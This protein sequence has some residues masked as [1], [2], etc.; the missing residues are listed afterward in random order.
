MAKPISREAIIAVFKPVVPL[1]D[2]VIAD[3]QSKSTPE[4]MRTALP[5]VRR[6]SHVRRLVGTVRWMIMA[7]GL[8]ACAERMPPGFG[9][10]STEAQHNGG[11]YVFLCPGG[12]FTVKKQPHDGNEGVYLQEQLN[13]VLEQAPLA[14]G[15]NASAGIKVF[16]SAAWK[17]KPRLI[18]EH[19]TL[20]ESMV[21]LLDEVRSFV[22]ARVAPAQPRTRTIVRSARRSKA[23]SPP[24]IAEQ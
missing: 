11:Q 10:L 5:T 18:V 21:I 20:T 9:V 23:K 17:R 6:E 14:Q 4:L 13:L 2:E 22:P 1:L 3:A 16:L 15:I 7:D 19:P 8:V 12:V 24:V